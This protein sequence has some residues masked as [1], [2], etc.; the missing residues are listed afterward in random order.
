MFEMLIGDN[1]WS[2]SW[3]VLEVIGDV[4]CLTVC[5]RFVGVVY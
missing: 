5:K 4:V 2:G 3:R 1:I